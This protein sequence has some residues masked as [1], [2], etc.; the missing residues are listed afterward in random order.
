VHHGRRWTACVPDDRAA[1][2][3]AIRAIEHVPFDGAGR[4]R[5][6][7]LGPVASR[8]Q[9][10]LFAQTRRARISTLSTSSGTS[11]VPL[12]CDSERQRP[13]PA[14]T[15]A[16]DTGW[17]AA[18]RRSGRA[19]APRRNVT[20]DGAASPDSGARRQRASPTPRGSRARVGQAAQR[21]AARRPGSSG[22]P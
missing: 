15:I 2:R 9:S 21:G 4:R 16:C 22:E 12:W 20:T 11:T 7:R 8:R 3:C 5:S 18:P 19:W 6:T 13:S 10:A 17:P 1:D 14:R